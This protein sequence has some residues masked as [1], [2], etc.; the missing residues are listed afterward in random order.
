MDRLSP[1][2]AS[3]LHIED[4][5]NL[6]HIGSVS[7]FEGPPPGYAQLCDMIAGRL[8]LVPRYRQRVRHVP[9]DLARPVWAPDPHFSL[10]YHVRHTALPSPGGREQ[11]RALVGRV[12]AQR[13]D[14][15]KPLWEVW[16]AEGLEEGRWALISKAHHALV[17]GISGTDLLAVLLDS[18]ATPPS[19]APVDDAPAAALGEAPSNLRLVREAAVDYALSPIEQWRAA[20][21]VARRPRRLVRGAVG[22]ARGL[23]AMS[24]MVRP[25]APSTLVGPIGPHRRYAWA[26]TTLDEVRT[27]RSGLGG[28]VN[29]VVLAA[30]TQGLRDLLVAHGEEVAGR[31]VRTLVPVSVRRPDERG[32]Y[33]NRVSAVFAE[34]PVGEDDPVARLDAIREQMAVLKQSGQAVAAESLTSMSGFA[35]A[36]LLALGTRVA[37]R[38]ARRVSRSAVETVTTN[39]P[40]PQQPLYALGRRMLTAYPYVPIA[41]PLRVGVAIFSYDGAI[42]FGVTGDRDGVPD[43]DVV[44]EGIEQGIAA[45]LT[46][47][48][49]SPGS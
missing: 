22:T 1:L 34:L 14:L 32:T 46:A 36:L 42:T 18:T 10:D 26:Q 45:L 37:F 20:R 17:D 48:S 4:D 12:M 13:L 28:S 11:L 6:M 27:V 2:D 9:F 44:T 25:R 15:T 7:V 5:V 8:E 23:A 35:P 29:D 49:A 38:T 40:G 19:P 39:V 16:M 43:V 41:S 33:N 24:P 30:V 47:A 3:F 31:R 21:S